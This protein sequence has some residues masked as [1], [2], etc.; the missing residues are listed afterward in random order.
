MVQGV[1]SEYSAD[2]LAATT[3]FRKLLSKEKNPPIEAV[4]ECGIV[5]K[6]V[7]FLR[8]PNPSLQFE[9]AWALTNIASGDSVQTAKGI[10]KSSTDDYSHRSRRCTCFY[11]AALFE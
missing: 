7:E 11:R 6:F 5:P 9:A 4:I 10:R 8:S 1:Q 2:Q 3:R